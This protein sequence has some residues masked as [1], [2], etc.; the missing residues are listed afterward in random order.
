MASL[1]R[2]NKHGRN[3]P[4]LLAQQHNAN[5]WRLQ[6][7][8][9][10]RREKYHIQYTA[11]LLEMSYFNLKCSI[12]IKRW[13]QMC[14]SIAT[15]CANLLPVWC[16]SFTQFFVLNFQMNEVLLILGLDKLCYS[17]LESRYSM[18]RGMHFIHSIGSKTIA[19][20]LKIC[21]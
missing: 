20:Y 5:Q 11:K 3:F 7:I 6:E 16:S 13:Y 2:L 4:L 12:L 17:L 1:R 10:S 15:K 19:M 21:K 18:I 14:Y 9:Q 8:L